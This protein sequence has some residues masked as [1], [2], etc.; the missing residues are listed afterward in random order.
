MMAYQSVEVNLLLKGK[1]MYLIAIPSLSL[2]G[3]FGRAST[4]SDQHQFC[5][6]DRIACMHGDKDIPRTS[7]K[8]TT[9]KFKFINSISS[10]L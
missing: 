2:I 4:V 5:N 1:C 9:W 7:P 3:A 10:H 8:E 6:N